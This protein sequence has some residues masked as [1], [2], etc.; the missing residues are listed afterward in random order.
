MVRIVSDVVKMFDAMSTDY[1]DLKDLFYSW[2]FSRIHYFI[3]KYIIKRNDLKK[4]LDIGCGTGFQSFLHA[5]A[6]SSVEAFDI[7]PELIAAANE[8]IRKFD[9]SK[10]EMFPVYFDFVEKYNRAIKAIVNLRL[11][12]KICTPPTFRVAN[13][14][15]IPYKN[16]EFDHINC[17]GSV[18]N[19]IPNYRTTIAEISRCLKR[20]GSFFIEIESRWKLDTLWACIDPL[21]K[22]KLEVNKNLKEGLRVLFEKPTRGI[23]VPFRTVKKGVPINLNLNLFTV[24]SFKRE[25]ALRGL[26][27]ERVKTIHSITNLI[28]YGISTTLKPSKRLINLFT[29]LSR[30]E[31]LTP[32]NFPGYNAAFIGRKQ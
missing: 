11:G 21:L 22:G 20:K 8:K 31:E 15:Q 1:D 2:F 7:S 17:C 19:F 13:A 12:S 3:A 28:P 9:Y 18:L 24:R 5:A 25:L 30:M 10:L 14:E 32:I 27:V 6:G 23:A 29:L 16:E 26:K 4:V